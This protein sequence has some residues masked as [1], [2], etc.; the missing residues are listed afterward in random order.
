MAIAVPDLA[1]AAQRFRDVLGAAVSDP[2]PLPAHGVT[3]VFVTLP[4]AKLELLEPLGES[5]PITGFLTKN[6]AGGIHHICVETPA[7]DAAV[8]RAKGS[9]VR[10]LGDIKIGA[11][12]LPVAFLHPKDMCGVLTELEEAKLSATAGDG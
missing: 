10:M 7:I 3:V 9:M 11:H 4:N 6:P 1:V 2:Q 5:S 12:G 8:A